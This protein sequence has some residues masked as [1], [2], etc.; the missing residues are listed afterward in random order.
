M[1]IVYF[2]KQTNGLKKMQGVRS[3]EKGEGSREL[4]AQKGLQDVSVNAE[5]ISVAKPN[6]NR[7]I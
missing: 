3:R 7:G 2:N 4:Y 5:T 6:E 1:K